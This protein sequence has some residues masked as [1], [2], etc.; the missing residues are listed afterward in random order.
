MGVHLL[1]HAGDALHAAGDKNI[2][3]ACNHALRGHRDGLQTGRAKTVHRHARGGDGQARA[4]GDLARDVGTSGTLG[5]GAAHD[6]V[7]NLGGF[8]ACAF[9]GMLHGVTTQGCA[10]GHVER[11]LPAFGQRGAG[12]GND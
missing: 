3:L 10:M 11:A 6:D 5:R 8:D 12:G 1:L 9:D 4:Q 7:V 2:A